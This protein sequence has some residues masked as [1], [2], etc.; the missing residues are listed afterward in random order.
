MAS[1]TLAVA[2]NQLSLMAR[3]NRLRWLALAVLLLAVAS[4]A[5]GAVR[6]QAQVVERQ[7]ATRQDQAIWNA[8]G[9]INPHGAA[10]A[11]RTVY[12]PLS[13][14]SVFEPGYSDQLGSSVK[15]EGHSQNPSRD[16]PMEGG[17]AISRFGGFSAAWALQVAA[18]L[19]IILAG[20]SVFSGER[21]RERLRQ[22]LGAGAS[23]RTLVLGRLIGLAAASA[24][25]LAAF[26][27]V[28]GVMLAATSAGW[29]ETLGLMAM[30]AG[31][32]LYLLTFVALTIGVSALT[33]S[34]RG[35]LVTLLAFW[36]VSTLLIPRVA[37]AV[38]ETL[39]PTPSAPA[40]EA[41]VTD[42]AKNGVSGHDPAD[43]RLAALKES[44]LKQHGV[45]KVEDLPFNF[46]GVA[47]EFG[48]KNSTDT[49][50]RHHDQ[51]F[52]AYRQQ[53]AIQQ[54]FSLVSPTMAA[55]PW[56]RAFAGSDF[57]AHRL[58]LREAEAYRYELIQALNHDVRINK[59]KTAD[60]YK[61][62]VSAI[63]AGL[64]FQPRLTTAAEAWAVQKSNL[65][66][67]SAWAAAALA[68]AAFAAG[69][70]ERTA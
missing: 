1:P 38:A 26:V 16:R 42:E 35:T 45:T 27:G 36:A 19:L 50:N 65:L 21:A 49:Y 70:L 66:I 60:P 29:G 11:G 15:L 9:S 31:Y 5:T 52:G 7:A 33:V 62:D 32:G 39:H 64:T 47:L 6:L 13:P 57:A 3:A 54:A 14:L 10:H 48:E 4:L 43:E 69:R 20:F 30:G 28:G 17:A 58:F 23:A 34:A 18:P 56:S 41:A 2:R 59:P 61:A 25:L 51:L 24:V 8:L 68:F 67:L 46:D 37:P 63:A 44:L 53:D 40:F 12:A 55:A 22:E